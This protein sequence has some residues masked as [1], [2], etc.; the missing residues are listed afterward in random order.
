MNRFLATL[1]TVATLALGTA[2]AVEQRP[3]LTLDI[4]CEMNTACEARVMEEGWKLD[5]AVL[6]GGG[7]LK[8]FVRMD[9]SY[10]KSVDIPMLK[11]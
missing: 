1:S 6:D 4:A 8:Y 5:I 9:D 7:N 11:A 10:S 3:I 2:H